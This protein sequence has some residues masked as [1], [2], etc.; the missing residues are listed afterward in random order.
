LVISSR[1]RFARSDC[2][3]DRATPER[4]EAQINAIDDM[5]EAAVRINDLRH[6]LIEKIVQ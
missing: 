5:R 4:A 1:G 6:D 2:V 3:P